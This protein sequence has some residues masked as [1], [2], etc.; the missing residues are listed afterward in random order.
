MCSGGRPTRV[1][2]ASSATAHLQGGGVAIG[3]A[4]GDGVGFGAAARVNGVA[5]VIK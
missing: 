3:V 2:I 5:E 1:S 4:I